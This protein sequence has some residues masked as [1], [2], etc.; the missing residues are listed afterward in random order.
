MAFDALLDEELKQMTWEY[1][2]GFRDTLPFKKGDSLPKWFMSEE[3][4]NNERK[5][6]LIIDEGTRRKIKEMREKEEFEPFPISFYKNHSK[7]PK[8]AR[9]CDV[10]DEDYNVSYRRMRDRDVWDSNDDDDEDPKT[11]PYYDSNGEYSSED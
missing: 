3:D 9:K 1:V 7:V 11:P 10:E 5:E 2:N 8:K 4:Y 6:M